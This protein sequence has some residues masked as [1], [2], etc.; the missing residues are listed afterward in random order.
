M[1]SDSDGF[2]TGP[3]GWCLLSRICEGPTVYC[4]FQG[5]DEMYCQAPAPQ[6]KHPSPHERIEALSNGS[7]VVRNL[8]FLYPA[9]RW[10]SLR[11]R[12]QP[13]AF[14]SFLFG[15]TLA[16]L[17]AMSLKAYAVLNSVPGLLPTP[18]P[19][20]G[21]TST[22]RRRLLPGWIMAGCRVV[23]IEDSGRNVATS[24]TSSRLL[25]SHHALIRVVSQI[26]RPNGPNGMVPCRCNFSLLSVQSPGRSCWKVHPLAL[27]PSFAEPLSFVVCDTA[28]SRFEVVLVL[29]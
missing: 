23:Q 3:N 16:L 6:E 8:L 27:G 20:H 26:S 22:L 9:L 5:I 7:T 17:W 14:K 13:S 15:F 24:T 25:M 29:R 1:R 10:A 4:H 12:F 28:L 2:A 19:S 18:P 11:Q 21:R